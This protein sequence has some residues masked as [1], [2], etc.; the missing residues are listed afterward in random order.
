[1]VSVETVSIIVAAAG[2]FL[3]AINQILSNRRA[4]EQR[5]T[6]LLMQIY[7]Q[8][9]TKSFQQQYGRVRYYYANPDLL[10]SYQD[11]EKLMGLEPNQPFWT[12][13]DDKNLDAY[14]DVN[15]MSEFFEGIGVLVKRKLIDIDVVEDLLANRIIWWW[16]FF[17]P[18]SKGARIIVDDPKL[19]DHVEYLYNIMKQRQQSD[20]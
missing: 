15:S 20:N 2:V 6:Q 16:E 5:Q 9:N 11:W 12:T 7:S 1:M 4:E 10:G 18:I 19:H 13:L 3:A 14:S 17:R 8:W